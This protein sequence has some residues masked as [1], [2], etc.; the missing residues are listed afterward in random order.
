LH[1]KR[2]EFK[3]PLSPT[4][5]YL[6]FII[7]TV[8]IL[9]NNIQWQLLCIYKII[10]IKK[11]Q[12]LIVYTLCLLQCSYATASQFYNNVCFYFV[13]LSVTDNFFYLRY[14]VSDLCFG[15]KKIDD[16]I[17]SIFVFVGITALI[18]VTNI[19]AVKRTKVL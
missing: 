11:C 1:T 13:F 17:V 15:K 14:T 3:R 9:A 4:H 18:D 7:E 5:S 12:I 19:C 10:G 8:F 2:T 6:N 16:F